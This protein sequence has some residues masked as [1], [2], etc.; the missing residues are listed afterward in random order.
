[1]KHYMNIHTKQWTIARFLLPVYLIGKYNNRITINNKKMKTYFTLFLFFIFLSYSTAQSN[2]WPK[3]ERN[4]IYNDCLNYIEKYPKLTQVQ[5][6]SI[7]L[8]Y[9]DELTKQYTVQEYQNKIDIEIKKIRESILTQCS[10][11][12]NIELI[13][14]NDIK[15]E[16][17][18]PLTNNEIEPSRD[19]LIGH[20]KDDN[21][22]FWLFETGDYKMQYFDGKS[23]KGTWQVNYFLLT[24]Y[25]DKFLTKSEKTFKILLF[26][27]DKFVYQSVK[28]KED[29]FTA[30]RVK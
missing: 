30:T 6:E 3:D 5:K 28:K 20:W 24:L 15:T 12:L 23:A 26:T 4:N 25:K 22:E 17:S 2:I 7:S 14:D 1:M 8:C 27:N 10:K 9:L 19:N 21:S 18:I 11:N 29:T 16:E 13:T